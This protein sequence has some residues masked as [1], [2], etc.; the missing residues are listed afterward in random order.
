VAERPTIGIPGCF[1]RETATA[2]L[3]SSAPDV[4][5]R[6]LPDDHAAWRALAADVRVQGQTALR[7]LAAPHD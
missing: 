2:D 5:Q 7:I 1:R 4:L 3:L 6:A